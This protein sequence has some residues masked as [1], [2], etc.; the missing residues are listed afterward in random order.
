MVIFVVFFHFTYFL[1]SSTTILSFSLFRLN[2][3]V[4]LGLSRPTLPCGVEAG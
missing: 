1:L 4:R 3:F 2:S